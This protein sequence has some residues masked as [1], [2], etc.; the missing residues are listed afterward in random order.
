MRALSA[1]VVRDEQQRSKSG[2]RF[3]K[4]IPPLIAAML[5]LMGSGAQAE[6]LR[7]AV[8]S[9]FSIAMDELVEHF[10]SLTGQAVRVSRAS[11]GKLYAQ[12]VNGAPFDILLAAD[13]ERPA[14]LEAAGLAVDGSRF[15]YATGRLVLW[16][17]DPRLAS[18]DCREALEAPASGRVAIANPDTAPYGA[19]AREVLITLGLWGRLRDRLV[20]GESI[21]QTL[22]FVASGNASLGFVA[23]AQL[24]LENLPAAAC[25]WQVPASLHSPI[26]QQAVLLRPAAEDLGAQA[27]LR[28]LRGAEARRIIVDN[29]YAPPD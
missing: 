17:R 18:A 19:A 8:A 23:A 2:M 7:I 5:I 27:F 25:L 15:T 14:L 13:A 24:G 10:E 9:N 3:L 12:I 11:T 6:A 16:S 4:P 29:G 22:Q 20:T 28:F 26:E 21:G 1:M